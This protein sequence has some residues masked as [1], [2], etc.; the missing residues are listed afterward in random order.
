MP[1]R[2]VGIRLPVELVDKA[3]TAASREH[4]TL[5]NYLLTLVA[6]DI[7]RREAADAAR[8]QVAEVLNGTK[9]RPHA[10]K[11]PRKAS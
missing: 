11:Q 2:F 8:V 1:S 4:R 5:S 3:K 10:R 6:E 7:A 9:P